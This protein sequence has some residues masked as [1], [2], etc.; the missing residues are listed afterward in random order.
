MASNAL[1]LPPPSFHDP[2]RMDD[3][4]LP[5]YD[6]IATEAEQTRRTFGVTAASEDTV[7]AAVF[8]IDCQV[9]F[10]IPGAS[11][12]VPGAL[13]D[14][15]RATRFI[16]RNAHRITSLVFSLDTHT[17]YQVFHP[18]FWM[19]ENSQ[20]PAPM[21][22]IRARDVRAGHWVPMPG[23]M[24][25]EQ[26][27]EYCESLESLGRYVLTIWPFH[28]MLG[29]LDHAL[30]PGLFEAAHFH[31]LMRYTQ[32]HLE[33]KGRH[34]QTENYSVL[35]PE[36]KTI[37]T[38][39]VGVFNRPLFDRL[40]AHDRIYVFGEASSH[41]VRA[42][43]GSL[44]AQV[45]AVAPERMGDIYILEDCM[46]PVPAVV[47]DEGEPLPGLDFPAEAQ[48]ALADFRAAGMKVVRSDT[49]LR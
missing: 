41:C 38:S 12:Y 47:D 44:Q 1:V 6:E 15:Q 29:A 32:V 14:M 3:L 7:R 2:A 45:E 37:G 24:S 5:R 48:A 42:T 39:L 9:G 27:V 16:L 19:D 26:A 8:G 36:V 11:L 33:L 20:H 49:I 31:S 43:L 17:A 22:A 40:M 21:T 35:E 23:L 4:H 28:T 13:E 34:P 30:V 10:C 46:S 25:L 18:S